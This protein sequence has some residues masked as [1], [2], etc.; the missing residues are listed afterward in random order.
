MTE[1]FRLRKASA[2]DSVFFYNV[3]KIVLKKYIEEIWGWDEAFQLKFHEENFDMDKT[4]IIEVNQQPAGTVEIKE[5]TER[6]FICSLYILPEYQNRKIG[7]GVCERFMKIAETQKKRICLEVLKINVNAQKLYAKLGFIL[8]GG[9]ET[10]Y[11]MF[12]DYL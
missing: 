12:K 7:T 4:F 1:Q 2:E 6:I 9:D 3:K 8:S 5:D 11:F 10:K